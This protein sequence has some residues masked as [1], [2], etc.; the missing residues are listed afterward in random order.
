MFKFG[1]Q[2]ISLNDIDKERCVL[3]RGLQSS[4]GFF[5]NKI[6]KDRFELMKKAHKK[7]RLMMCTGDCFG[8][9]VWTYQNLGMKNV[10]NI[11]GMSGKEV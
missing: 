2:E 1:Y 6:Q 11:I 8:S 4:I 3:E 9:A 10:R 5:S 7:Y